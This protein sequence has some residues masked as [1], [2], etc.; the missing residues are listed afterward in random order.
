MACLSLW[1]LDTSSFWIEILCFPIYLEGLESSVY[2]CNRACSFFHPT[3]F[4]LYLST[5]F[6]HPL[7]PTPQA[8][9]SPETPAHP[10]YCYTQ[11]SS[12]WV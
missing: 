7:T 9:S 10:A 4:P 12:S 8:P 11:P 1:I 5:I 3:L 2:V 6:L